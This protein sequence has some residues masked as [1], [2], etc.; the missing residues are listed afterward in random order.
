MPSSGLDGGVLLVPVM[1]FMRWMQ[2][3]IV[4]PLY[5]PRPNGTAEDI[6]T[7]RP[8]NLKKRGEISLK[9]NDAHAECPD[10]YFRMRIQKG[11]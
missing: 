9:K 3:Q 8:P 4:G 2:S 1:E 5:G 11:Y 7:W 10:G 6:R